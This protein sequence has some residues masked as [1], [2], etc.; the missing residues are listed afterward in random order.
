MLYHM[1][2]SFEFDLGDKVKDYLEENICS[3]R[4]R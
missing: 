3:F 4:K 1:S 2:F